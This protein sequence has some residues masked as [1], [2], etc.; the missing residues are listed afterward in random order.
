MGL[1]VRVQAKWRQPV[2]LERLA[3]ALLSL[4]RAQSESS[5]AQQ[6]TAGTEGGGGHD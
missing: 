2:D 6:T 5:H 3:S 1:R 4:V